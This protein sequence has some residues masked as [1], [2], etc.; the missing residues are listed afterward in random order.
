MTGYIFIV[1]SVAG[2][3]FRIFAEITQGKILVVGWATDWG[4]SQKNA[5][6]IKRCNLPVAQGKFFGS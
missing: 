6:I 2:R 5:Y 1:G 3:K 4:I